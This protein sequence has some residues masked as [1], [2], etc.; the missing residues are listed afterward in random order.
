MA[1]DFSSI[2]CGSYTSGFKLLSCLVPISTEHWIFGLSCFK[3]I[4]Y[5]N[6]SAQILNF[7]NLSW[8]RDDWDIAQGHRDTIDSTVRVKTIEK[9]R[10]DNLRVGDSRYSWRRNVDTDIRASLT[11]DLSV[12][13]C[14]NRVLLDLHVTATIFPRTKFTFREKG[15]CSFDLLI[16]LGC[17]ILTKGLFNSLVSF[18][19]L[20]W[21][22]FNITVTW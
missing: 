10:R 9:A 22:I 11:S 19:D 6:W 15:P 17:H 18:S 1:R 12:W 13:W 8:P 4:F 14:P 2:Y 7:L 5:K 3:S 16:C 21:H 20:L